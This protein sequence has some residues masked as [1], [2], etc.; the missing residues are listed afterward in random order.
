MWMRAIA[1]AAALVWSVSSTAAAQ[2]LLLATPNLTAVEVIARNVAARGGLEAWRKIDTMTWSGRVESGGSSSPPMPFVVGLSRPNKTHFE[3]TAI[4]RQFTRT[5]DGARGWKVRPGANGAP[6]VKSFSNEEVSFAR[7]EFVIDGPLLDYE[8]KGVVARLA[9]LDEV[10]GRKAYLLEL[11]LPSGASR[12]VW[13]DAQTYLEVR[14]DRPS[15]NPLVKGAPVSVY[16]R[17]YRSISGLMIPFTIETRSADSTRAAEKLVIDK[18][19][20]NPTLPKQA[21][22]KPPKARQRSAVVRIGGPET[23]APGPGSVRTAP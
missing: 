7:D 18:V 1:A 23:A 17:D 21:F 9:G 14:S 20:L 11:T 2:K 5:F 19:A 22:A 12:R 13:I 6:E 10:D 8:A 3:I 4:D 15:I 16:Y